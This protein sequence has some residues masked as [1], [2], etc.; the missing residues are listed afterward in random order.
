M[1]RRGIGVG[2]ASLAAACALVAAGCGSSGG[3]I[4]LNL[5]G[6]IDPGGTNTK[7]AKECSQ[8]S[9]GQ[10]VIKQSPVANSADAT[11]ELVVRRLAAGDKNIDLINMDTIWTPEFAEAGWLKQLTGAEEQDALEDV[12]P[13]PK[14]SVQWKGKTYAVPLNTNAQLLWYRKDLVPKP[15]ETWDEMIAMAKKL[16][17]GEGNI[18]EQGQKYEGYVVWFNNL[19]ASAGGTIVNAEGRPTLNQTAVKAAQIIHDVATSGRA[20]PSLST[21]QEDPSRLAFEAGK[22]AFLLNWPYVYAAARTDGETNPTAKKVYENMGYARYPGVNP[23]QPSKVS[24]G[25][26]NLGI[27]VTGKH[28]DLA[29]KAALCMTSAK[30]QAQEAINDGLPP[31]MNS[32]YDDPAVR[33]VYPFADLLREQLKDSVV[34]P[35]TPSYSDVTLAIQDS[36]HPPASINPQKSIDTLRS[37]L[38]TLADGGMY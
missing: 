6:P 18:L 29:T 8:Q 4:T 10:Y 19:V 37:R 16:P 30:W 21:A 5:L 27:P 34:R 28:P 36:L 22:G 11:R 15:P 32:T 26:A 38:N 23:G 13:G 20:D 2:A 25:G 24:I 31:V 35:P 7:A 17:P 1:R 3:P 14:A 12:L 9:D 33:K